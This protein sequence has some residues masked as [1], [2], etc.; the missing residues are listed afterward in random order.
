MYIQKDFIKNS[1]KRLVKTLSTFLVAVLLTLTG[2]GCGKKYMSSAESI[3]NEINISR[4]IC[5]LL[6]DVK[7]ESALTSLFRLFFKKFFCI[8]IIHS[9]VIDKKYCNY[10]NIQNSLFN[11]KIKT[12]D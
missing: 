10:S 11:T 4:G 8:Y 2:F 9:C 5:V 7:G 6:G 1:E 12:T 3:L